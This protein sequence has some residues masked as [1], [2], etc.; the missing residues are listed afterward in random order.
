M[1]KCNNLPLLYSFIGDLIVDGHAK[2][3]ICRRHFV[4]WQVMICFL[5]MQLLD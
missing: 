5:T 2:A 3:E 4:K 1:H